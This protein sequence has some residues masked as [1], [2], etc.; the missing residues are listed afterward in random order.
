MVKVF[1]HKE[2]VEKLWYLVLSGLNERPG[3]FGVLLETIVITCQL[4]SGKL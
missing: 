2:A 1:V 4:Y 3:G